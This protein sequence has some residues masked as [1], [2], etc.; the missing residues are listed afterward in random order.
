MDN[1]RFRQICEKITGAERERNGIGTL[2]EKT[3]HAVLKAYLEEDTD[4]H[5]IKVGSYYADICKDGEITEIQ[6]AGFNR[7]RPKLDAFLPSHK[8]TVVYPIPQIKYLF[9]IDEESGE[10]TK[11]RKS[12]KKAQ[13]YSAFFELYK[14]NG[15][16]SHPNLRIHLLMLEL[17][18]YRYL[19]GY[20]EDKKRGS[21]RCDRIPLNILS[22]LRLDGI[23]DYQ[24][25]IPDTL[26]T[27]FTVKD[28]E[29]AGGVS[30]SVAGTALRVLY[31]LG[32]V[33][34]T[35]KTGNAFLYDRVR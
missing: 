11:K 1:L 30:R 7:L 6:T 3:L 19:N 23:S 2:G 13:P 17:E 25:M 14:I 32:A 29:K 35:G 12:P 26:E 9:W 8:V 22:E 10:I 15:W 5:E 28:Y 4:F 20:S 16:L 34:R 31:G 21:S 27:Q 18:E 24:K 33:T